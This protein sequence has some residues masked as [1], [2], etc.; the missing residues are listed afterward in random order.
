MGYGA[1]TLLQL[2]G[3]LE[4]LRWVTTIKGVYRAGI[5]QLCPKA[6]GHIE[7]RYGAHPERLRQA[8]VTVS[9][10]SDSEQAS[11]VLV[12]PVHNSGSLRFITWAQSTEMMEQSVDHGTLSM[13]S[14]G[15]DHHPRWLIDNRQVFVTIRNREGDGLSNEFNRRFGLIMEL[16]LVS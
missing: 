6:Y 8:N 9:I 15:V 7:P 11:R 12:Q 16:D 10:S 4:S 3:H 14:R 5:V 1:L 2:A 13:S